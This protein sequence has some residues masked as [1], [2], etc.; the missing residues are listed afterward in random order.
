MKT[1][2]L[3][4]I[5]SKFLI[6][7]MPIMIAAMLLLS[8]VSYQTSKSYINKEIDSKMDYKIDHTITSIQMVLEKHRRIPESLARAVET[9]G[10]QATKEQYAALMEK[11]AMINDA[12]FG[13]GVWFEPNKYAPDMKYFGPYAYKDGD[14]AV[15]TEDYSTA[16]YDYFQWDW[17]KMGM[18]TKEKAVWSEPYYDDVSKITMVTTTAPFYDNAGNFMGV[19][20]SDIDLTSIQKMVNDIK[21]GEAGRAFLIDKAGLYLADADASKIMKVKLSEDANKSLAAVS[22]EILGG[23]KASGSYSDAEG[24]NIIYYAPIPET[25]WILTLVV[26]EKQLLQPLNDLLL[27]LVP[28]IVVSIAVIAF[29]MLLISSYITKNIRKVLDFGESLGNCDLTHTITLKAKDEMGELAAALNKAGQSTRGLVSEIVESVSDIASSSEELS[30]LTEEIAS[31]MQYI[32]SSTDH[33]VS[34]TETLSATTQQVSSSAEEI[35]NTTEVLFRKAE[36][37]NSSAKEIMSRAVETKDLGK[38]SMDK[39]T[40]MYEE[41]S[42]KILKAIEEGKVVNEVRVVTEA[43]A[44]ISSQ[45]NMLALNA[46][47]EAA[48]AGEAGKGF[49]VV[50]DEVRKLAEQTSESAKSIQDM[51]DKVQ[52]AFNNLSQN[53]GDILDFIEKE[54]KPD[55]Q[56][57]VETGERYEKD[58]ELINKMSQEVATAT[59]TM[60]ESISE[61]RE[62]LH[63]VAGTAQE[64]AA[65]SEDILGGVNETTLSIEEI[66]KSTQHQAELAENLNNIV[67]KFKI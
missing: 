6:I 9:I 20:T 18:N 37:T 3:R 60:S 65:S 44:S 21:I 32:N 54:V 63:S 56:L 8:F 59:R 50:A 41:K 33:I 38:K 28:V 16:E 14:K 43:I 36:E 2:G 4:S 48:R 35:S 34:G 58:A 11:F 13:A 22:K 53:A 12:T 10:T 25:G 17:Y 27:K 64:S 29:L 49:A 5:R 24:N 30:A 42:L 55:Y 52:V 26:P 23:K 40:F 61:I 46:A 45:T 67:Q 31:K 51:V 39:A 19:T 57:L 1:V 15:Y 66:A 7:F 62:A 47:I